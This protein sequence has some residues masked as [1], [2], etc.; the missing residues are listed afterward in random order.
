MEYISQSTCEF[1]SEKEGRIIPGEP[2]Y[3]LGDSSELRMEE[4]LEGDSGG[5]KTGGLSNRLG[6]RQQRP[7]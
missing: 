2:R 7:E 4:W 6:G 3:A 5:R 1:Y